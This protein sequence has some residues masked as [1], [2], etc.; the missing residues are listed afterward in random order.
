[1]DLLYVCAVTLLAGIAQAATGFGFGLL[2]MPLFTLFLEP[3]VAVPLALCVSLLGSYLVVYETRREV[4]R[5]S[6]KALVGGSLLGMPLGLL[7]LLGVPAVWLRAAVGVIAMGFSLLLWQGRGAPLL[8]R[9]GLWSVGGLAGMLGTSCGLP[10]PPVV[11]AMHGRAL[12]T[13]GFR[14][15][16]A[17]FMAVGGTLSLGL[18]ALGGLL[19]PALIGRYAPSLVALWVANRVG[20]RLGERVGEARFRRGV[21]ALLFAGALAATG[22]ALLDL[23]S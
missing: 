6:L 15:T 12:S 2:A 13:A 18:F 14:G 22:S 17:A 19:D 4:D 8:E 10:G 3:R 21:L 16:M 7:L 11:L 20:R 9:A 23:L 1:V 5:R